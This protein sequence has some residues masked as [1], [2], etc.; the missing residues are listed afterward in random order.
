MNSD[1][2]H[3]PAN[4]QADLQ[5][6]RAIVRQHFPAVGLIILYGSYARGDYRELKDL[7]PERKSGHPS[8]YDILVVFEQ[9]PYQTQEKTQAWQAIMEDCT[10]AGL[11]ATPR[12]I[13][14][15]L[16]YVNRKLELGQYFFSDVI[17]EG[18]CLYRA[19]NITLAAPR[20]LSAAERLTIAQEDYDQWF[21]NAQQFFKK[22]QYSLSEGWPKQAAFDLHQATEA[23]Y[24]TFLIIF[25][26]YIPAEHYLVILSE[27]AAQIAPELDV[28]T[29]FQTDVDKD[30]SG[31]HHDA[32]TA[33]E[34]AYIGARYE[35]NY[36][37][38]AQ[39]IAF[40]AQRVERL[41][42]LVKARCQKKIAALGG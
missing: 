4:K 21:S 34:Y 38:D 31:F 30:D 17:N 33:L 20:E 12:F 6:I 36:Q 1:L 13:H 16:G 25:T 40:L 24:K 10:H 7:A 8:D 2:T 28:K 27:Q 23:A 14:H 39:T 35:K 37:I 32:F 22:Y 19:E 42:D 3:L 41:L 9:A 5:Q 18:K 29:L 26:G 11:S 15:E